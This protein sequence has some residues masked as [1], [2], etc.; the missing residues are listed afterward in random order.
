MKNILLLTVLVWMIS[1]CRTANRHET[2][3]SDRAADSLYQA[4][5]QQGREVVRLS[6]GALSARLQQAIGERGTEGAIAFC[7]V[8]ALPITDSL[9]QAMDVS[10]RRTAMRYRNPENAPEPDDEEIMRKF[11]SMNLMQ[12]S[13]PDTLLQNASGQFVYLA[14]ILTLPACLQCHGLPETDIAP[15]TMSLIRTLYPDDKAIAFREMELRGMWKITFK[16][17]IRNNQ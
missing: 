6:F 5:L 12:G 17:S 11:A 16:K 9:S 4:H 8:H 14:P 2:S 13:L 3:G 7:N 10:I 1:G 15:Q